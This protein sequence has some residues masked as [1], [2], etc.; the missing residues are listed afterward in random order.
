MDGRRPGEEEDRILRSVVE[1]VESETGEGFFRSLVRHLASALGVEYAFV[2][3]LTRGGTHFRTRAVWARGAPGADFEV[4]LEGTPC[5]AVLR[6]EMA[7]H[8]DRL[9]ELFPRDKG[10]RGWNV[11]GY[12]GFPLLE[13]TGA[14]VGHL[15]VMHD[16]P[17]LDGARGMN[18]MRVFAARARAELQR[19][20][21]EEALRASQDRLERV[22]DAASDG[23]LSFDEEGRIVLFNPAAE[24]LLSCPRAEAIGTLAARFGTEEG[25]ASRAR[26]LQRLRSDPGAVVFF[27]ED[28]GLRARRA[29]GTLFLH[30]GSLSRSVVDG[31]SLY[32]VI[33][34]D[35]DERRAVA[36]T[37]SDLE[38][39]NAYLQEEIRS[40]HPFDEIVGRS[41]ALREVLRRVE[42]VAG[43]D[44]SVLIT[45][46]TGTG[47]ELV[48][49]AIHSHGPRREKP[50]VKVN[51]AA[52]PTGLV[53]SELFGHE[54][55]AFTG[56]SER[57][58]GR[59]E[60]ADGGTIFLD[61]VG[62]VPL[63]VQVKLLR[64]LQ[65]RE[66]ERVGGTRTIRVD[67]RV[68][69]ATNRDLARAVAEGSFRQDLF[70]RLNVFPVQVPPLRE[71]REDIPLLVHFFVSRYAAKIGRRI[72]RV[73]PDTL[74]RL[75]AYPWPGNVRE[76]ENVVERAVILAPGPALEVPLEMLPGAPA[77]RAA[78][79][80]SLAPRAV[81]EPAA[82]EED[83]EGVERRHIV[84]V[85]RRTG[86]RIDGPRGAAAILKLHPSTLR[87]RMQ[88]LGIRRSPDAES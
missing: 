59:F 40:L 25:M 69:A 70:Y 5:E 27:G 58:I 75:T 80:P 57:R 88:R 8:P 33:F 28:E 24:R 29:D 71:R 67:V 61:E 12:L 14:V 3:E 64:V 46:E 82:Q 31:Q 47:K 56:A 78:P 13:P 53:E 30:E 39:Q 38:R 11:V 63:D 10:L 51:C 41:P 35:V 77:A 74:E 15:A 1:G 9:Q 2:S 18:V 86:W 62:E 4:P 84:S 19:L 68:I 23:I 72:G 81:P 36:R 85:L 55:G 60:L 6:G 21:A 73:E 16:R 49:R 20:R 34:R 44:S 26:A 48:A 32:T 17:L 37:L 87:S 65:E 52:L 76:L 45:G 66:L 7:H 42:L 54:K 22:F 50:L 83:L 79:L 43:T